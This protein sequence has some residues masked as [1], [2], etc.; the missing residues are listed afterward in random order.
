M[1][2]VIHCVVSVRHSYCA[3]FSPGSGYLNDWTV[4]P[5][6]LAVMAAMVGTVALCAAAVIVFWRVTT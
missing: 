6:V 4:N 2:L 1:S 5:Y 3:V